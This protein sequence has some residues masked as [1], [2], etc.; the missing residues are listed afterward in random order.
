MKV[1]GA[2]R[3]YESVYVKMHEFQDVTKIR[4]EIKEAR[5]QRLHADIVH[6]MNLVSIE[7]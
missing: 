1:L 6:L 4:T 3:I 7:L 5:A 2:A